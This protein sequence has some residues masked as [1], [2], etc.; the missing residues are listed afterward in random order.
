MAEKILL[1]YSVLS[2]KYQANPLN[3]KQNLLL[4]QSNKN[5]KTNSIL[6]HKTNYLI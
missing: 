3:I 1:Y 6:K 5:Y 4:I 2:Q